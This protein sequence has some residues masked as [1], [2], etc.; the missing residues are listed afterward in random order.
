MG[1]KTT[2]LMAKIAMLK[3][4]RNS[5]AGTANSAAINALNTQ[6]SELTD[7][8]AAAVE[9]INTLNTL[10]EELS[11]ASH[12]HSNLSVISELEEDATHHLTYKGGLV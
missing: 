5:S 4:N 9:T 12:T 2:E 1:L 8:L 7:A 6:V 3:S 11:T 10:V